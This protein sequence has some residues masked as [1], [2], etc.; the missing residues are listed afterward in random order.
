MSAMALPGRADRKITRVWTT[1]IWAF[2]L[3]GFARPVVDPCE[4]KP[5]HRLASRVA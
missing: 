3:F 5:E 2:V 4:F 1:M